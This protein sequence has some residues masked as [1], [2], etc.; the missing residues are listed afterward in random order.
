MKT[1]TAVSVLAALLLVAACATPVSPEKLAS[2]DYGPP[3]PANYEEII[4]ARFNEIL[5]DPTAPLYQIQSPHKGY[6]KQSAMYGTQ[7]RFG[8][9]VC[10]TVNSKNRMGGYTG[11]LP[12]FALFRGGYIA[13]FIHGEVA[14]TS[15]VN[16]SIRSAC[17]RYVR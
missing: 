11:R 4:K 10:G 6:T 7:E 12:F 14:D 9:V 16:S 15:I 1:R 8:W 5:I 2:A 3:P 17:S 13:E